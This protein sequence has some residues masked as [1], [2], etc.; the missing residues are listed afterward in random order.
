MAKYIVIIIE[1]HS[2]T[3]TELEIFAE[4]DSDDVVMKT[5]INNREVFV[6]DYN[7]LPA[8]QKLRDCLLA[9]G[10]GIK[11]NG[12]RR[13]AVQSGMMGSNAKIYL[14]ELGRQ[15][16]LQDIVCIYDYADINEFPNTQ[17]QMAFLQK[18]I[19]SLG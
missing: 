17:E 12:S 8:Y 3:E 1:F 19:T 13:N 4:E 18:W 9:M 16:L 10:Y 7:Y 15:A 11:C 6:S 5:S 2:K 14:V